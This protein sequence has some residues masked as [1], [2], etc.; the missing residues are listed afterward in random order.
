MVWLVSTH[1]VEYIIQENM[2]L[3]ISEMVTFPHRLKI[4]K[5]ER[6]LQF[7]QTGWGTNWLVTVPFL[8]YIDMFM[9]SYCA[10]LDKQ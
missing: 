7:F 6:N 2:C 3:N 4:F 5:V 9:D 8:K 10:K 1:F